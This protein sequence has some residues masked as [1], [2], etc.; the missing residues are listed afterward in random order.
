MTRVSGWKIRAIRVIRGQLLMR[1]LIGLITGTLSGAT[2]I[3]LAA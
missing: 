1:I 2:P 3:L